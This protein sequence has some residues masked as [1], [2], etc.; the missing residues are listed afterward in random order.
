MIRSALSITFLMLAALRAIGADVQ[1]IETIAA[2]TRTEYARAEQAFQ[3]GDLTRASQMY[4]KILERDNAQPFAWFRLGLAHHQLKNFRQALQAYDNAL[5]YA[6]TAIDA[7]DLAATV[8]KT[9]FNRALLLLDEVAQDLQHIPADG[10]DS[11][12]ESTRVAV[13]EYVRAALSSANSQRRLDPIEKKSTG[14]RARSYVYTAPESPAV[15]K[16]DP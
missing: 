12:F 13:H 1:S 7:P 4:S 16:A 3:V 14:A 15:I 5:R 9:R 11:E 6:E 2:A 8:A 10:L